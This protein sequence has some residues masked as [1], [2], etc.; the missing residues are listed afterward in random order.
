MLLI[1]YINLVWSEPRDQ[2]AI[3]KKLLE[4]KL[5]FWNLKDMNRQGINSRLPAGKKFIAEGFN[6]LKKQISNAF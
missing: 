6:K 5:G 4:A 2:N 1:P 3:L